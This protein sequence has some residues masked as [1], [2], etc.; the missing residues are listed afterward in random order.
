MVGAED[1][2]ETLIYVYK[3][4]QRNIAV[5]HN[6]KIKT[7]NCIPT[8]RILSFNR[9]LKITASLRRKLLTLRDHDGF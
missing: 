4:A 2:S 8:H 3:S 1:S 9:F 5:D 7:P 6:N